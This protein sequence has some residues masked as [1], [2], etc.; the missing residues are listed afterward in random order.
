MSRSFSED[1]RLK[2]IPRIPNSRRA[3]PLN[4][5]QSANERLK[6]FS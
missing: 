5:P 1:L 6:I 2:P 4:S 3:N